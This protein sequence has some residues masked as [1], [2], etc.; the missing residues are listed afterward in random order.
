VHIVS[1]NSSNRMTNFFGHTRMTRPAFYQILENV[2][3]RI[4]GP[5]NFFSLRPNVKAA[6]TFRFEEIRR[7][8]N[9][10]MRS[11]A[12]RPLVYILRYSKR[13]G[14]FDRSRCHR[15]RSLIRPRTRRR[16]RRGDA[17]AFGFLQSRDTRWKCFATVRMPCVVMTAAICSWKMFVSPSQCYK[18]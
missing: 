10:P 8:S 1:P 3:D 13:S 11:E 12:L 14:E 17:K 7:R 15:D 18:H 5:I 6:R 4:H 9:R 2:R 16:V